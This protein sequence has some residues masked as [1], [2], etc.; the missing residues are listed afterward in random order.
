MFDKNL[1]RA[2]MAFKNVTNRKLAEF[3]GIDESTLYRKIE[4]NGSFTREEINLIITYL[5]IRNPM[6]IFF[7]DKLAETQ[8]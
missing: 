5:D 4:N 8:V 6:Q 7:T 2:Q 1:F 3:L